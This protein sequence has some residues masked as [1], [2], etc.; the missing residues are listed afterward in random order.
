MPTN[1]STLVGYIQKYFNQREV[2][3][4]ITKNEKKLRTEFEAQCLPKQNGVEVEKDQKLLAQ[5]MAFIKKYFQELPS[6]VSEHPYQDEKAIYIIV[7]PYLNDKINPTSNTKTPAREKKAIIPAAITLKDKIAALKQVRDNKDT[8]VPIRKT[9][10]AITKHLKSLAETDQNKCIDENFSQLE[11]LLQQ[12]DTTKTT[13]YIIG[14]AY[15]LK[16]IAD[17][18]APAETPAKEATPRSSTSSIASK[19][20]VD[21]PSSAAST[22]SNAQKPGTATTNTTVTVV[23]KTEPKVPAK[24]ASAI[25]ILQTYKRHIEEKLKENPADVDILKKKDAIDKILNTYDKYKTEHAFEDTFNTE[26]KNLSFH[27]N[28]FLKAFNIHMG[29]TGYE[30]VKQIEKIYPPETSHSCLPF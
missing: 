18:E 27:R 4:E 11:S 12:K 9:L 13:G 22:P 5:R 30:C 24:V 15:K 10:T 1:I 17:K 28:P 26:K 14:N 25:E 29:S 8:P 20:S 3:R 16:I 2:A 21:E 7:F 6:I 19:S 23:E